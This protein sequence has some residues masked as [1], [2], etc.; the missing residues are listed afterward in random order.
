[1]TASTSSSIRWRRTEAKNAVEV[2]LISRGNEVLATRRTDAGG[3]VQFEA[4][5]A[6]GEGGSAPA[7][8]AASDGKGDYAFLSLKAPAFDLTDR[9]VGGRPAPSGLDAFVYAERGVYRSGETV[10]S[11][12]AAAQIRK[13]LPRSTCR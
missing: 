11:H 9:G 3:H 6:S 8:L 2:R 4:G 7:M 5:L 13:A 10:L 1:M 12:R